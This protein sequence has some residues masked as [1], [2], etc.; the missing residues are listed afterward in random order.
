MN[1]YYDL[2]VHL[3]NNLND[4]KGRIKLAKHMGWNGI[5]LTADFQDTETIKEFSEK[6]DDMRKETKLTLLIGAEITAKSIQE[7]QKNSRKALSCVDLSLVNGGG[8]EIN[9]AAS[10]CWEVDILCH[11]EKLAEKDFMKQ[12]NSGVDHV[13]AKLMAERLIALEFN[14]SEILNSYGMLRSH[15]LGRMRQNVM[16][17]R[18]YKALMILTSGAQ[19]KW[20]LRAPGELIAIG[21][22]IGMTQIEAKLAVSENPS[23]LLKKSKDRKDPNIILKGLDVVEWG[24]QKPREKRMYGWY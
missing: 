2:H 8:D 9:R 15:V 10:E 5:C 16:L 3:D 1:L 18:K 21:K 24:D 17:A 22:A 14:F 13:M 4:L 7:L 19:D 20:E 6:I 23:R 12:K 11:P